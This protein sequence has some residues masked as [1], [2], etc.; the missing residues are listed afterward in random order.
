MIGLTERQCQVV[1]VYGVPSKLVSGMEEFYKIQM[2]GL[3]VIE[4]WIRA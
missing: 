1:R 4:M 2:H 3:K